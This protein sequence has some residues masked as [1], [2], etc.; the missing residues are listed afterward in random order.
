MLHDL[1]TIGVNG[2]TSGGC[3]LLL[4]TVSCGQIGNLTQIAMLLLDHLV[5][6][7]IQ[8]KMIINDEG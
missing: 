6:D 4:P 1:F 5:T 3:I 8:Y 7:L 2:K